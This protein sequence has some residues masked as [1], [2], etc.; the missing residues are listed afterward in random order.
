MSKTM[1]FQWFLMI[2]WK[3]FKNHFSSFWYQKR[4]QR[5]SVI[6]QNMIFMIYFDFQNV[7]NIQFNLRGPLGSS[8]ISWGSLR[9]IRNLWLRSLAIS[10]DRL[11]SSGISNGSLDHSGISEDL[12]VSLRISDDL[13][14]S[15]GICCSW[16]R[17]VLYT[18]PPPSGGFA[19]AV[20]S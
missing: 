14:E 8:G 11:R 20:A 15:L 18:P 6:I 16:W 2:F 4:V 17:R 19:S 5:V 13:R 10:E 12:W 9:I 7:V 3:L 1:N